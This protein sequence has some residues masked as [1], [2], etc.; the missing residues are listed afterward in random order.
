MT[1]GFAGAGDLDG[2]FPNGPILVVLLRE[3]ME[4]PVGHQLRRN[5]IVELM[6]ASM[7]GNESSFDAHSRTMH[8]NNI[9]VILKIAERMHR[10][11]NSP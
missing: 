9:G 5:R 6:P 1:A 7:T 2:S 8:L 3:I 11:T 4:I 10:P